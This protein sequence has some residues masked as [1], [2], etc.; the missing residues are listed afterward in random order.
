MKGEPMRRFTAL[1]LVAVVSGGIA[2][3]S[4]SAVAAQVPA[5]GD[6]VTGTG[7]VVL[8]VTLPEFTGTLVS[9]FA[10]DAHSGPSGEDPSGTVSFP[11]VG[12][13]DSPITCLDVRRV[14][15]FGGSFLQAT[16]N[17]PALG[18]VTMQI[19]DGGVPD[20]PDDV[21]VSQIFSPRA[22]TDCS[23]LAFS[24]TNVRG[25]VTSGDVVFV[26]VPPLPTSKDQ[27][28]DDGWR[29]FGSF[30]RSQGDCVA[31]VERRG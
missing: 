20:M 22:A 11:E 24:D 6:S 26:D 23:P 2:H 29:N 13:V 31:F 18:Q 25:Q 16:M 21:V 7:T 12:I 5:Y 4:G 30:F 14:T 10:L 28:K 27:C 9:S 19:S 15:F 17:F 3:L 1:W 8:V